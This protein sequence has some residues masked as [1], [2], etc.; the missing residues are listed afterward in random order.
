MP[1]GADTL[2]RRLKL[3][4]PWFLLFS[5]LSGTL[6]RL[7]VRIRGKGKGKVKVKIRVKVR[8]KIKVKVKVR[9]KVNA[10]GGGRGRPPTGA[11]VFEV[12]V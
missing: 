3:V 1:C 10:K 5:Q 12:R 6:S 9:V 11:A 7:T 2:V 8:V 4:L